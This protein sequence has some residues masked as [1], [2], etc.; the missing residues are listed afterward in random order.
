MSD[1]A[2]ISSRREFLGTAASFGAAVGLWA[3][4]RP[5]PPNILVC[6]SDDQ[7]HPH[8]SAYGSK[9]VDT[10]AFDRVAREGVLFTNAF[11]PSPGCSPTRAAFLTGQHDWRIENAGTHA[12]SF[13]AK[14]ATYPDLLEQAGYWIGY[15]GKPWGPGNW[16]EERP[17]NPAGAEFNEVEADPPASGIRNRDY[18]ANFQSFLDQRPEGKRFCFWFGCHEPHR[19]FEKGSGL[20]AGKQL[21][22]VEV[23][24]FLPDRE[25]IRSDMLDYALEIEHFDTHLSRILETLERAGEIDNTLIIVTSD[26]GMAFPRAK[27]NCY[28]Y[29]IHMPLAIRWGGRV[30]PGRTVDDL[31]GFVDLTATILDAAGVAHPE[32][33]ELSGRSIVDLLTSDGEGVVDESRDAVYSARERHSSSRY[34]N[35]TYPQRSLRT[36]DYLYIRNFKSD[37]W[38]AGDPQKYG[39]EGELEAMHDAYQDIDASPSKTFLIENRD[40]PEIGRFFRLAV[41]KRPAEELFDIRVDPGCLDNLAIKPEHEQTRRDLA[42]KLEAYL[43]ATGDPRVVGDGDV[44][45]TYKRYSPIRSFPEPPDSL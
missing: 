28:E 38:P 42:E 15:T 14:F 18:A 4:A 44:W 1:S 8:A 32:P 34:N 27:A 21:D 5:S 29:G 23:P 13:P 12:S 3:C 30:P 22:D 11:S 33:A 36:R 43:R 37:R 20:A 19:R 31:I 41:D 40:D 35:W 17:R 39:E 2:A 26:N 7:S 45:E 24:P 25:E 9:F 10:P 16:E 6:I